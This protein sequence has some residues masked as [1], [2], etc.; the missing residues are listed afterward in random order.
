[1]KKYSFQ[2]GSGGQGTVAA[3]G[4]RA[5][6]TA[7]IS[8]NQRASN[9]CHQGRRCMDPLLSDIFLLLK[10]QNEGAPVSEDSRRSKRLQ[11]EAKPCH[12]PKSEHLQNLTSNYFLLFL[13]SRR[14]RISNKGFSPQIA[15]DG[16]CSTRQLHSSKGSG[17]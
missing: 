6:A 14:W 1:M 15:A 13:R 3:T 4:A 5:S 7:S 12:S 10:A 17:R 9:Y 11:N 8:A 2:Q 16:S